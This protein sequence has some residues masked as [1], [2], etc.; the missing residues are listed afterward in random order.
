MTAATRWAR[1]AAARRS[2]LSC[3]MLLVWLLVLLAG[4]PVLHLGALGLVLQLAAG[5]PLVVLRGGGIIHVIAVWVVNA[6]HVVVLRIRVMLRG[7]RRVVVRSIGGVM[8]RRVRIVL[9]AAV[10]IVLRCAR[11]RG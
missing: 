11:I 1:L 9:R 8:L 5:R 7:S 3:G 2:S 10:R 4:R 6:A